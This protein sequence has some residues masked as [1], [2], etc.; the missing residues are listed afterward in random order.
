[1]NGS[2]GN[3]TF[4]SNAGIDSIDGGTGRDLLNIDY[5]NRTTA[6]TFVL[7]TTPGATNAFI[8]QGTTVRNVE[9][10][11]ITAG[12]GADLILLGDGND[13]VVGGAGNDTIGGGLGD[14]SLAGGTGTDTLTYADIS[15]GVAVNL[16]LTTAQDT[17]GAGIDTISGFEHL[18]GGAG[19]D[20]LTGT[21][22]ANALT[23]GAGNDT[24]LGGNGNDTLDGGS[25]SDTASFSSSSAAITA[26]LAVTVAQVTG[27]GTDLLI[28]IENLIGGSGAD[29]LTGDGGANQ[30]EG[31]A[32]NDSLNGGDGDDTLIGGAGDDSLNGGNGIDTASYAGT[33]AA[34]S[35]SLLLAGAQNTGGAGLDTLSNIK[36]LT[37][38]NGNDSLTGDAGANILEGGAGSDT[39]LGGA[40]NDT[41]IGGTG[42]DSLDGGADADT[43]IYGFAVSAPVWTANQDGSWTITKPVGA[44]SLRNVETVQF[45]NGVLTLATGSFVGANLSIA[46]LLADRT[47]GTGSTTPFT[48]TVTRSGD[49]GMAHSAA[50]AVTGGGANAASA[51]DFAGGALPSGTVNFATGETSKTITVDVAGDTAVEAD[52]GFT[53]TL[54]AGSFG[55]AFAT[56]SATGTIRNDDASL[57]IAAASS[58][59]AEGHAGTT[60]F[61]FTVTRAGDTSTAHSVGWAV[62]GSGANAASA[63]DFV[64]GALPSGTVSFAAGETSKTITVNVAGD[65][66]VEADEGFTVTLSGASTGASI[67]TASATGTVRNDDATLAIAAVSADLPEGHAGTTAFTFTVTR[68]GDTSSAHSAAWAVTGSGANAASAADFIGGA[69]PSGTVSFAAGETSKTITVNV[70]GDAAVEADEG[71]TVTLSGASAGA[72]IA[73]AS[74]SATGTIRNDDATLAIAATDAS[75]AEGQSGSTPFTFTVTRAGD[76]STAHSAGWAVT[77]SGANAASAADFTGGALPSGDGQLRCRRDQQDNHRERRRRCRAGGRRG[78]HRHP[79]GC[80]RRG[81]HRHRHGDRHHLERRRQRRVLHFLSRRRW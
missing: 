61:T 9:I 35:V 64:G 5:S 25:G 2:A 52:E 6:T 3:D 58:D 75:K 16:A 43:V 45:A 38:G 80:L 27:A 76:T 32:G 71:F 63:A 18:I 56:A 7:N 29:L 11:S 48:F 47:E 33:T 26:S 4:Y 1:M 19:N 10:F 37:G 21:S 41:L 73:S 46:P 44:D 51:T 59:L 72:N 15:A 65:A 36:N 28:S 8:G 14:D 74:A 67:G 57:A 49:T 20:S 78:L 70:A 68:A 50:W 22:G 77:G 39:V 81:R 69:L 42:S 24:L 12:S 13:T 66:A 34:V 55:V 17:G 23:G 62:T 30:L 54:S 40:G 53:V 31:G 60:A 79:L